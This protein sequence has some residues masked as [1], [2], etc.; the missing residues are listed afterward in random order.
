M[1]EASPPAGAPF[2]PPPAGAVA[3][4]RGVEV[5]LEVHTGVRDARLIFWTM[6]G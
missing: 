5:R 4:A 3:V 1:R 2:G 6:I